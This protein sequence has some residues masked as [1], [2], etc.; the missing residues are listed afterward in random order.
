MTN[1]AHKIDKTGLSKKNLAYRL[2]NQV[3][4]SKKAGLYQYVQYMD[5]LGLSADGPGL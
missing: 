3:C 4:Q 5:K 2:I 1:V